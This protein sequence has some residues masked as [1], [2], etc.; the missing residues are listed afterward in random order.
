LFYCDPG[1]PSSLIQ[2]C[3]KV[4]LQ[5]GQV[6]HMV[7]MVP[8]AATLS[9][10]CRWLHPQTPSPK[11]HP[12]GGLISLVTC[13]TSP[14]HL[15]AH[16]FSMAGRRGEQQEEMH[17]CLQKTLAAPFWTSWHFCFLN[18]APVSSFEQY[19]LISSNV[20]MISWAGI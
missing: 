15:I 12:A 14:A 9:G 3:L 10:A 6:W 18:K 2:G 20:W 13:R 11:K 7:H 4:N 16:G 1:L 17:S 19:S 8:P 5:G